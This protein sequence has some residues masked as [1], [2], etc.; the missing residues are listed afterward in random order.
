VQRKIFTKLGSQLTDHVTLIGIS[1]DQTPEIAGNYLAK[2]KTPGM[3]E[4]YATPEFRA[5]V[6]PHLKKPVMTIPQ[7]LYVNS[8]GDVMDVADSV[9]S[10]VWL[11]ARAQSLQ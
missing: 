9:Q 10:E 1:I 5:L 4:L 6:K 7:I 3:V 8:N 11:T 2:N